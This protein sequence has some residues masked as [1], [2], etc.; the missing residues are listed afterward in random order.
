M[1]R[2]KFIQAATVTA[3][4]TGLSLPTSRVSCREFKSSEPEP[5]FR[6]I[7]YNVLALRGYPERP[8]NKSRLIS[9]RPQMTQRLA[10]ELALYEPDLITFQ[11]SPSEKT[12]AQ[13]ADLMDM[14]HVWFPGGFPGTVLSKHKISNSVNCPMANNASRPKDLF[15][16][17]WGRA[18]LNCDGQDLVVYTAHLHPSKQDVR[19]REVQAMLAAMSDDLERGGNVILQGDLNMQ[20]N[21]PLYQ[22][23]SGAGLQDAFVAKGSGNGLTISAT[24]RRSRID[25]IWS[26]GPLLDGLT[27]CRVLA[28]GNFIDHPADKAGFALSDHLPVMAT[29]ALS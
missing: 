16:R 3:A 20:P 8:E 27:D 11:E 9:A 25:Y 29:F 5:S 15:T 7:S 2:R 17:H 21:N 22:R 10:L 13:I 19:E 14:N 24:D 1:D 4:A 18:V 23:W 26:K 28:E 12:V 6:T